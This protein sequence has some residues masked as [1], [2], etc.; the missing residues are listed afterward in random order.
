[1]IASFPTPTIFAPGTDREALSAQHT[2]AQWL[3]LLELSVLASTSLIS[4]LDV[5][6]PS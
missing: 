4:M 6:L 3:P 2:T 5:L 1:M